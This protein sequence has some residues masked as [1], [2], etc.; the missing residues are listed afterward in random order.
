MHI[1]IPV[2][3][4]VLLC[5]VVPYQIIITCFE[6]GEKIVSSE[7]IQCVSMFARF[8]I[9]LENQCFSQQKTSKPNLP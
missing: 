1:L 2:D 8:Y 3:S 4:H 7:H 9:L 5:V 6:D